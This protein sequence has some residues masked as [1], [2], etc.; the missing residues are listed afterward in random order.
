MRWKIRG[1][2]TGSCELPVGGPEHFY[3]R[4]MPWIATVF[5]RTSA[6]AGIARVEDC[7]E[8]TV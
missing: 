5:E 3:F 4:L 2:M 8:K 7:S 6:Q 1:R